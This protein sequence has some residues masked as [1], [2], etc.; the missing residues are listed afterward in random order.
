[1]SERDT[2]F[3]IEEGED[4]SIEAEENTEKG[5]CKLR[6]VS[7]GKKKFRIVRREGNAEVCR[8]LVSKVRGALNGSR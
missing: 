5:S 8:A 6:L 4:G 2:P 7:V 3:L 1:M